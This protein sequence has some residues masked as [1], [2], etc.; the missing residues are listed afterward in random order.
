MEELA[1]LRSSGRLAA[2][3]EA[4]IDKATN[5][6]MRRL[7]VP[8]A[9]LWCLMFQESRL[10]HLLGIQRRHRD[11]PVSVSELLRSELS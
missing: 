3:D 11:R 5:L 6:A 4:A 7:G 10:N 8:K 1:Q 2:E 9:V